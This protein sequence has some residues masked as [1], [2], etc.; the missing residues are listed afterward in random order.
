MNGSKISTGLLAPAN[1]C[2]KSP[3]RSSA[4]GTVVVRSLKLRCRSPSYEPMKKVLSFT[5]GPPN[6]PPNWLRL[7]LASGTPRKLL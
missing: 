2:E 5:I 1:V 6:V 3:A 4:V 7:K